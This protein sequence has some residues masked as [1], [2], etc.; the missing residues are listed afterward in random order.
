MQRITLIVLLVCAVVVAVTARTVTS[1]RGESDVCDDDDEL[2]CWDKGCYTYAQQC[3]GAKD[4]DDG[5]DEFYCHCGKNDFYCAK[6]QCVDQDK[7]CNGNRDCDD[8]RDEQ[9]CYDLSEKSVDKVSDAVVSKLKR[10]MEN[11]ASDEK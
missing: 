3:D 5:S 10:L 1:K 2:Y 9:Y 11:D 7:V 4:C 8:G 6:G